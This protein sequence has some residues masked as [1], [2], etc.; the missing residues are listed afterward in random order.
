MT[1]FASASDNVKLGN[2][3]S[4]TGSIKAWV[5]Y[6]GVRDKREN[7]NYP[8]AYV[9]YDELIVSLQPIADPDG[10]LDVPLRFHGASESD[11]AMRRG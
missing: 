1:L 4:P 2:W 7:L 10:D 6:E 9:W 3:G 5:G 8:A 11:V